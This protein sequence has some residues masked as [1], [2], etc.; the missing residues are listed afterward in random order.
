M[1]CSCRDPATH[2]QCVF[3]P[4]SVSLYVTPGHARCFKSGTNLS[5]QCSRSRADRR[6]DRV[7]C[8]SS[9]VIWSGGSVSTL[10]SRITKFHSY[11]H[12]PTAAAPPVQINSQMRASPFSRLYTAS[13]VPCYQWEIRPGLDSLTLLHMAD[14]ST[15]STVNARDPA[16]APEVP[17]CEMVPFLSARCI[18]T[19][20]RVL[21]HRPPSSK[22]FSENYPCS[23]CLS[24]ESRYLPRV[25]LEE[26]PTTWCY[27]ATRISAMTT[28]I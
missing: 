10:L 17:L 20:H 6:G 12:P 8:D 15:S 27:Q 18:P 23:V 5:R 11:S 9:S 21:F 19:L 28:L 26:I 22:K 16:M 25:L 13:P 14:S 1:F 24:L 2:P 4:K 7:V 3:G